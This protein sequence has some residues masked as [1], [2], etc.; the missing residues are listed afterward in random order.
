MKRFLI[1]L[2][3]LSLVLCLVA[4]NKDDSG[5]GNSN[6]NTNTNT[7]TNTDT[8]TSKPEA[9]TYTVNIVDQDGNTIKEAT[10]VL[11]DENDEYIE[12]VTIGESG[13]ATFK[14]ENAVAITTFELPQYHLNMSGP[15]T[16]GDAESIT[17]TIENNEPNGTASRPYNFNSEA[18]DFG[19]TLKAG[20]TVY[21]V[22][23]GGSGREFTLENAGEIE[24]TFAGE[25]RE[26][27]ENGVI[28]FIIPEVEA[29]SRAQILVFTNPTNASIE[30]SGA[31]V[32]LPGSYDNP[33]EI[34]ELDALNETVVIKGTT[35]YY[36]FTATKDGT[37]GVKSESEGNDIYMQNL[38]T[39][40]V[41][42]RTSGVALGEYAS[43]EVKEGE[44]I[45]I[46]VESRADANYNSVDFIL[47][48]IEAAE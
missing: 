10:L 3:C 37:V 32:S 23:Y 38:T 43:I 14:N 27:D 16:L 42:E 20:E 26:A 5:D 30:L 34:T 8:N 18:S 15:I 24:F 13:Y 40:A 28:S 17:F 48:Y 12:Y 11:I 45:R 1:L 4:C 29:S 7:E 21:Y 41:S 6:T 9:K 22:M 35:V 46:F 25:K 47:S 19:I 2:I 33:Y 31:V 39:S 36:V 44:Q